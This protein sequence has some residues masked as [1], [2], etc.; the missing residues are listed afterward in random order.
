M[1]EVNGG[2]VAMSNHPKK[3]STPIE[4]MGVGQGRSPQILAL[5]QII[6]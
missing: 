4:K 1:T 6:K 3:I 2:E 5:F